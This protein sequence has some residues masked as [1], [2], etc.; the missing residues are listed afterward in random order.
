MGGERVRGKKMGE[1]EEEGKKIEEF[2]RW[3]KRR[4]KEMEGMTTG[5]E[6]D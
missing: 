1:R 3:E 5:R 2:K 6:R 4:R